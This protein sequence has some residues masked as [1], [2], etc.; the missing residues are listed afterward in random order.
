LIDPGVNSCRRNDLRCA[1]G[2]D[3]G[4]KAAL[5]GDIRT[6][7]GALPALRLV[8]RIRLRGYFRIKRVGRSVLQPEAFLWRSN[9]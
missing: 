5:T 2:S 9:R 8:H 7:G 3:D 6:G 4:R 1:S